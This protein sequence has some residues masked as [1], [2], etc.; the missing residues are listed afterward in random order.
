MGSARHYL[1]GLPRLPRPRPILIRAIFAVLAIGGILVVQAV[2]LQSLNHLFGDPAKPATSRKAMLQA[3]DLRC[4]GVVRGGGR[5][6][7]QQHV[8]GRFR[9]FTQ[10][11]KY[12]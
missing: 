3:P 7:A 12:A 9:R 8:V 5:P 6:G 4:D 11:N 10:I 2:V 1:T